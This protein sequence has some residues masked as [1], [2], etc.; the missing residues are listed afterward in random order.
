MDNL[1]SAG[2]A[3]YPWRCHY[4]TGRT[5]LDIV[6]IDF[7]A[8]IFKTH[9]GFRAADRRPTPFQIRRHAVFQGGRYLHMPMEMFLHKR[10]RSEIRP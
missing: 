2:R 6:S 4:R 10:H 5:I 8:L 1:P 9:Q 7:T 3:R